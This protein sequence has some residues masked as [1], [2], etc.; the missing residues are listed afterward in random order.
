MSSGDLLWKLAVQRTSFL[1]TG[2]KQIVLDY[3]RDR[4]ALPDRKVLVDLI[5]R[6]FRSAYNRDA[7]LR[8]AENDLS[9]MV[10]QGFYILPV[11]D[12]RYPEKLRTVHNPPFLLYGRGEMLLTDM[13]SISVV[14]TRKATG[15]ALEKAFALSFHLARSGA[16]VTSGLAAGIDSSA[17]SGALAGKG[18]TVAVFGCGIDRI[19]PSSN[20]ELAARILDE[21]GTLLSE[22][23]PGTP[24]VRY[25]FPERNR[26]VSALSEALVVVESPLRSGA[27]ITADFALEQGR[28]VFVLRTSGPSHSAGEGTES[29][30]EEGAVAVE[31]AD[32]ILSE[33]SYRVGEGEA[34]P[35]LQSHTGSRATGRFLADRFRAELE[36]REISR[37]GVYYSL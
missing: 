30:M 35:V 4:S 25:N 14:G 11:D 6:D 8:E 2:E 22:Y 29:L 24:P 10:K 34:S 37:E 3:C 33:L 20:K 5:K 28:D 32:D 13:V 31:S 27:L 9:R 36:G 23:P 7:I 1:K 15:L 26:I 16:A 12:E 19:Y 21:G 17:H 18:Y